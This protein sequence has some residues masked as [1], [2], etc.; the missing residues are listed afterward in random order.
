MKFY[1]QHLLRTPLPYLVVLFLLVVT[2]WFAKYTVTSGEKYDEL[3]N[4][5]YGYKIEKYYCFPSTELTIYTNRGLFSETSSVYE[6]SQMSV[7]KIEEERWLNNDMVVYLNLQLRYHDSILVIRPTRII[8]D[9]SQR[10]IYSSS[11]FTLWR[12]KAKDRLTEAEF[13]ALL[14]SLSR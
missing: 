6:M 2:A 1:L 11:D 9:F 5:T 12:A 3:S 14:S 8:Y 10:E 13:N 7:N 4:T